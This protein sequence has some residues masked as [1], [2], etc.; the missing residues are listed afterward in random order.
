MRENKSD[1]PCDILARIASQE[2]GDTAGICRITGNHSKGVSF[3]SWVKPTFTD[4]AWLKPGCIISNSA[5]FTMDDQNYEVSVRVGKDKPQRFRN[6][7]HIISNGEWYPVTKGDKEK[8]CELIVSGA[9]LVSLN[10]SGQRHVFFKHRIGM[11]QLDEM[12]IM[13]DI[14]RFARIQQCFA[15][16]IG[17]GFTQTEIVSG[18]YLQHRIL[19][20]GVSDWRDAEQII[21]PDRGSGFFTFC[22]YLI[23]KNE[24]DGTENERAGS[25]EA[26]LGTLAFD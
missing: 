19:K 16:L 4:H 1:H 23:H 15:R 7:S 10:E 5:L 20:A 12:F 13:P 2:Y 9:E 25:I 21:S 3:D 24:E 6:Y 11:W 18:Q 8:I 17:L 26:P 22:A 14:S